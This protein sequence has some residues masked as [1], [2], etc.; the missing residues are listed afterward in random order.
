MESE[1]RRPHMTPKCPPKG[2]PEPTPLSPLGCGNQTWSR[3]CPTP[4]QVE[5]RQGAVSPG[6]GLQPSLGRS[7]PRRHP[8]GVG[9]AR[10]EMSREVTGGHC[11]SS[12]PLCT[13][14]L[15]ALST[16]ASLLLPR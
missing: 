4:L 11:A 5:K 16:W 7:L 8:L 13:S 15:P 12:P 14:P 3:Q 1:D 6:T 2:Y 9:A 10:R